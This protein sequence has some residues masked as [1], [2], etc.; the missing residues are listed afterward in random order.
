MDR[1]AS[2]SP[3]EPA[4]NASGFVARSVGWIL[5]SPGATNHDVPADLRD[6]W[7]LPDHASAEQR[8]AALA[9]FLAGHTSAK[10]LRDS[11]QR[12]EG[13]ILSEPEVNEYFDIWQLKLIMAK[14]NAGQAHTRLRCRYSRWIGTNRCAFRFRSTFDGD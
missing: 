5:S 13:T 6:G 8:K 1:V 11:G 2:L 12:S 9:I 14:L 7:I 3:P 10:Q 4:S